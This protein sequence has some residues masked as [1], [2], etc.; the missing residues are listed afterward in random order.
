MRAPTAVTLRGAWTKWIEQ[1][2]AGEILSRYRR[3]YKPSALRGYRS[4]MESFVLDD[5]GSCRLSDVTADD[6]QALVDRLLGEGKSGS[7]VRNVLV[8]LQCPRRRQG[9][10]EASRPR[11]PRGMPGQ[12]PRSPC[13]HRAMF[14]GRLN[15]RRA[16]GSEPRAAARP[17][18]SDVRL[19]SSTGRPALHLA[20][21]PRLPRCRSPRSRSDS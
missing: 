10:V 13:G 6:L 21:L 19:A 18:E 17:F 12:S 3:P 15:A 16:R 2:E 20:P 14:R 1:A 9:G 5:F 8:P 11:L 4:D 7:K